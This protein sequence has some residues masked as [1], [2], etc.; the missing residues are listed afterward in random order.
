MEILKDNEIMYFLLKKRDALPPT[1]PKK[2]VSNMVIR[3]RRSEI[4]KYY[5]G[6]N[7]QKEWR[8]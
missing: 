4:V 1:H 2:D 8:E 5:N 7:Y 6:R 3:I